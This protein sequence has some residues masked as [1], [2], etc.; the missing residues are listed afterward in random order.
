MED[1]YIT[2]PVRLLS[3]GSASYVV[4]SNTDQMNAVM[5]DKKIVLGIKS[6]KTSVEPLINKKVINQVLAPDY[7]GN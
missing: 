1:R 7:K 3:E 4:L 6:S 2:K 5:I